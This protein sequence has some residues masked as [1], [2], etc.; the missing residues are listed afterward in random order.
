MKKVNDHYFLIR[1]QGV[2]CFSGLS[3]SRFLNIANL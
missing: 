1:G 3:S 2:T